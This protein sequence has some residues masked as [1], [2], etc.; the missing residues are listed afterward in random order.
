MIYF[1]DYSFSFY[2]FLTRN[3]FKYITI[4][5]YIDSGK[6]EIHV[7]FLRDIKKYKYFN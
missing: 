5:F 4:L 6:W 2:N 1:I 3:A 7:S